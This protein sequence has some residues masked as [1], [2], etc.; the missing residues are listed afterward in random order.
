[1]IL[2]VPLSLSYC[3]W[4]LGVPLLIVITLMSDASLSI[5]AICGAAVGTHSLETL[6]M[7][8]YGKLGGY[9]VSYALA[10]LL[11]LAD[12]TILIA[13]SDQW[14][15]IFKANDVDISWYLITV[16]TAGLAFP[17][18]LLRSFTEL[19][20]L[21]TASLIAIMVT[22]SLM[23]ILL[24][25]DGAASS[26]KAV[27]HTAEDVFQ[28]LSVQMLAFC[29]HFNILPLQQEMAPGPDANKVY[30]S[31]IHTAVGLSALV[32]LVAGLAGYLVLGEDTDGDVLNATNLDLKVGDFNFI[33]VAQAGMGLTNMLKYP[34]MIM[35]LRMVINDHFKWE[36]LHWGLHTAET[37]AI[38]VGILGVALG[39][40]RLSKGFGLVGCSAGVFVCFMMPGLLYMGAVKHGD[41]QSENRTLHWRLGVAMFVFG[42]F[43]CVSTLVTLILTW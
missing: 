26:V 33:W 32:Y 14:S 41:I 1:V 31:A 40:R 2:A 18:T 4:A 42:I 3:G 17:L 16:I 21:T 24:G 15:D 22:V 7:R 38:Q 13:S 29:C 39:V 36:N 28:A 9:S 19:R 8:Y 11:F 34:L 30:L 35:P 6:M 23:V 25:K 27:T 37:L 12:V 5:I 10:L 43:V 20:G